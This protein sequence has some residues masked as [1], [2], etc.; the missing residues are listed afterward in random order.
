MIDRLHI[1]PGKCY[2]P[3][4]LN[5]D[6]F[7]NVKADAYYDM[8]NMPYSKDMFSI[9]Y[10]SH[11]LEHCHRNCVDAT[12]NHWVSLLKPGGIIRLAVPD[13]KAVCEY[14]SETCKLEDLMGLLYGAQD[15]FL[16]RHTIAFDQ[17][18]LTR[19]M[20]RAGLTD[21]HIWDWRKTDHAQYDDFS[22]A[23]LPKLKKDTG[24]L[25]SLNLQGTKL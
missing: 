25:M 18:T 8:T 16:N 9:I 10:A 13:F 11:V 15:A 23:Y 4:F 7:S 20:Q 6:L 14:Y 5:V 21:V 2:L 24:K 22:Q 19:Y 1:G 3:G 17:I 12:L